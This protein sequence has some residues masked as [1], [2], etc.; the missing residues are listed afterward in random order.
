MCYCVLSCV[1]VHM[2]GSIHWIGR[3]IK[4]WSNSKTP[5]I[6][7]LKILHIYK[8]IIWK[9]QI[10]IVNK[11]YSCLPTNWKTQLHNILNY[12][13]A[14]GK[15]NRWKFSLCFPVKLKSI[16]KSHCSREQTIPTEI[17]ISYPLHHKNRLCKS[18]I[19]NARHTFTFPPPGLWPMLSLLPILDFAVSLNVSFSS[20]I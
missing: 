14:L 3:W 15:E 20:C 17:S 4:T 8:E 7:Q 9:Y 5:R 16:E 18:T 12:A 2:T 6:I 13:A 1:I 19:L 10:L 11:L